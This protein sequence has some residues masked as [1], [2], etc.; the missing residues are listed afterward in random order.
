MNVIER[1]ILKMKQKETIHRVSNATHQHIGI[2]NV[3]QPINL[4]HF[5]TNK[6]Q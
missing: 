6:I 3:S 4:Q 2:I 1:E 5:H